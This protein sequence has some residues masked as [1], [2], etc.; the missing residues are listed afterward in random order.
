MKFNLSVEESR[1]L[2]RFGVT[3]HAETSA[4]AMPVLMVE[5]EMDD[6]ERCLAF[7]QRNGND[8]SMD[9]EQDLEVRS[10]AKKCRSRTGRCNIG[11][12]LR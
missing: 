10:A 2:T 1:M 4:K 9:R 6:H 11:S 7:H 12:R 5:G 8:E 3:R